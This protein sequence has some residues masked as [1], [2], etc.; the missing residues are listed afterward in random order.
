MLGWMKIEAIK[1]RALVAPKDNLLSAIKESV[2]TIDEKSIVVVT[3]KVV[4][5]WQ[6]RCVSKKDAPDKD[7]LIIS[8][9]D[10]YIPRGTYPEHNVIYTI[11]NSI[12]NKS[13]GLDKSNGSGYFILWPENL[14]ETAKELHT[15]FK[16]EYGLKEVG[17]L[18][19]DSNF[20]PFRRGAIGISLAHY[21]FN[22]LKDYR[23]A[24]DIFN[25]TMTQQQA[26]IADGLAAGA[27]VAMGEGN[28]NTPLAV[29]SDLPNIEFV[30]E[31]VKSDKPFSSFEVSED[32]D[33]FTPFI[34]NG[35]WQK[36]GG[37]IKL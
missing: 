35:K 11:K 12:L 7:A 13:A 36:G 24:P 10:K 5:I 23:G 20:M 6:G 15:W 18:I 21:G 3:S 9:A 26:N 37:G 30:D 25:K 27:V 2:K 16:K 1:T 32:E 33:R 17:I 4:S 19:T 14:P 31:P 29:I 22:P 34:S 28:E 8:E